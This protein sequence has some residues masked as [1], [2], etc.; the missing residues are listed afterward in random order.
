MSTV[1]QKFGSR[2]AVLVIYL[3]G[4]LSPIDRA[5]VE[6]MLVSDAGLRVELERLREA[7]N[8][9]ASA[10]SALDRS[11]RLALPE[12]VGVERVSRVLQDR[13]ARRLA[14]PAV[15]VAVPTLPFP[16]W[17]YP[18]AAAASVVIAFLVWWG[19]SERR[20]D[21]IAIWQSPPSLELDEPVSDADRLAALIYL[22]M[23]PI[24]PPE[25]FATL[26][27]PSD[28]AVLAPLAGEYD[29]GVEP[30][31]GVETAPSDENEDDPF[32]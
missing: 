29:G 12:S 4:E 15:S 21:R 25:E 3:A 5:E 28:F 16:W 24:E 7:N 20:D 10:M 26:F 23:G 1:L 9:F 19:N 6:Q 8:M 18:L 30:P 2:E 17:A 11:S 13:S 32:L 31:P 27:D 22:T 14:R